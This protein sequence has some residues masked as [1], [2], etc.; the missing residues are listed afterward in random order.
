MALISVTLALSQTTAQLRDHGYGASAS[1][2]ALVYS[3]AFGGTYWA[4]PRR[5]S[6]AELTWVAD[7]YL[8]RWF[9]RS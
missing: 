9:A 7:N 4:Y 5:G 2:G 1:C 3:P 8:P 6:Q